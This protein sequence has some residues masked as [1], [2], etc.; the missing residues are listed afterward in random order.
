[1]AQALDK[2]KNL[3]EWY[4]YEVCK[5]LEGEPTECICGEI[6]ARNCPAHQVEEE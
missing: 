1:M 6:N 2:N 5:E 3:T 4:L